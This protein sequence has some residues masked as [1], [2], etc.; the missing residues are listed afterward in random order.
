MEVMACVAEISWYSHGSDFVG[1]NETEEENDITEVNAKEIRT[2]HEV[3]PEAGR[4]TLKRGNKMLVISLHLSG[5][6]KGTLQD[7]VKKAHQEGR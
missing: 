2:T 7:K 5:T 6:S 3:A 4:L 1:Q